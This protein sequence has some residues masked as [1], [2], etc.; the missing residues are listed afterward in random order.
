MMTVEKGFKICM[1][2]VRS[3][4]PNID[5]LR[6]QFTDFDILGICETWLN[7]SMSSQMI[8]LY[9]YKLFR[10]DRESGK[11]GRGLVIYITEH[12]YEHSRTLDD[13]CSM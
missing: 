5:E 13:Y 6:A 7:P 9:K 12:L 10:L 2:N 8:N 4:W 1:L 3:L 11:R